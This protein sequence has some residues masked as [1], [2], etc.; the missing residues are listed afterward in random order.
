MG[1]INHILIIDD[2][3]AL[4]DLVR[5][6]LEGEGFVVEATIDYASGL[7]A[8]LSG[9]HEL[10]ILDVTLPGGSGF[11][12]LK[13]LRAESNLPVLL[14]TARGDSVDR[15]VGLQIGAD[16]Y[17]PKPF[18]PREVVARIHAVLRR[19]RAAMDKAGADDRIVV[20]DVTLSP[21][22]RTATLG[23]EVLSLTTAEFDLLEVLLRN[24]GKV[25][26]RDQLAQVALGRNLAPFDRGVDIHL[27]KLRKKLGSGHYSQDRI[28]TVRGSGYI[29]V[30]FEPKADRR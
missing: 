3:R 4:V 2:D 19:T 14:L 6:Y 28:K 5:Q 7:R 11:E 26:T 23:A 29:Y 8:A 13:K 25:V 21:R 17:V 9:N 1:V 15:I 24:A 22:T 20:G 27:S 16:D 10:V 30:A 12:L 18:E